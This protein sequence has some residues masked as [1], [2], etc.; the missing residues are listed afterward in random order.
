MAFLILWS[1]HNC[2]YFCLRQ[3]WCAFPLL[4]HTS[5]QSSVCLQ[6]IWVT[7]H[8]SLSQHLSTKLIFLWC[9]KTCICLFH[10]HYPC[11]SGSQI[12]VCQ[13]LKIQSNPRAMC[14]SAA[15]L[16][17]IRN[18]RSNSEFSGMFLL[19]KISSL[20]FFPITLSS[21]LSLL[22]HSEVKDWFF[23]FF[24]ST[25]LLNIIFLSHTL[26][27]VPLSLEYSFACSFSHT[28]CLVCLCVSIGVYLI[29]CWTFPF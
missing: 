15:E 14:K 23:F 2:F 16:L 12:I 20:S 11:P 22:L 6:F 1:L 21:L 27:W 18:Q 7:P 10:F 25:K 3:L 24:F 4:R 26:H 5:N 28:L 8:S 19:L 13:P 17:F 9:N 29:T